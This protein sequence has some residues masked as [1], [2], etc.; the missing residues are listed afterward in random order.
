MDSAKEYII[1]ELTHQEYPDGYQYT[2]FFKNKKCF[3]LK[4]RTK[5]ACCKQLQTE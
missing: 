5:Y 3:T 2:P 4:R 1:G